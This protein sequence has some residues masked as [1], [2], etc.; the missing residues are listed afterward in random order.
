MA[1]YADDGS[2]TRKKVVN[3]INKEIVK[4]NATWQLTESDLRT[5]TGI[6]DRV[7]MREPH[8]PVSAEEQEKILREVRFATYRE[9]PH[10]DADTVDRMMQS[11]TTHG[12]H[13]VA[14]TSG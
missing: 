6:V 12:R 13:C 2:E 7:V 1:A 3:C 8:K 4:E 9:L 11:L 5:F 14:R 10:L